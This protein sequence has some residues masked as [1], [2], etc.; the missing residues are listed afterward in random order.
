M[1]V[2]GVMDDV[3]G[4]HVHT[5]MPIQC[6]KSE[7]SQFM[8]ARLQMSLRKAGPFLSFGLCPSNGLCTTSSL[9]TIAIHAQ[10]VSVAKNQVEVDGRKIT[11]YSN[12][13]LSWKR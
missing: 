12:H 4:V 5:T 2:G 10:G 9:I 13:R 1:V 3:A 11:V 7:L 8:L 6:C